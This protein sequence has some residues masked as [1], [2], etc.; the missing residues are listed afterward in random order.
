MGHHRAA[1]SSRPGVSGA[2][3]DVKNLPK[4][5]TAHWDFWSFSSSDLC[6]FSSRNET[7]MNMT[8]WL[9]WEHSMMFVLAVLLP[10]AR[11]AASRGGC[12]QL[13]WHLA[14]SCPHAL[15]GVWVWGVSPPCVVRGRC[16][17]TSHWKLV[18]PVWLLGG[19]L[20]SP[21]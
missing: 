12:D 18:R 20:M 9:P 16:E 13:W 7:V 5:S 14:R 17:V 4:L 3:K 11:A 1:L 2:S 8:L 19:K 15:P 6:L 10:A 21:G